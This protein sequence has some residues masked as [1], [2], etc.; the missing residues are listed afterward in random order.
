MQQANNVQT[1]KTLNTTSF[2][3]CPW[4]NGVSL[5]ISAWRHRHTAEKKENNLKLQKRFQLK[6]D[7]G[8]NLHFIMYLGLHTLPARVS[9]YMPAY[10]VDVVGQT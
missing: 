7:S 9:P 2:A 6:L 10:I 3:S 1:F 5:I 8:K 4:F